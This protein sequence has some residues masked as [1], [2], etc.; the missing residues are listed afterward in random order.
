MQNLT[1]MR[2]LALERSITCLKHLCFQVE[3]TNGPF[4][5][6]QVVSIY[7]VSWAQCWV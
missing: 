6:L 4:V 1:K 5:S 3:L 2:K 7:F